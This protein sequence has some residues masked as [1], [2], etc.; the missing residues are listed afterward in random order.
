MPTSEQARF[1]PTMTFQWRSN[2]TIPEKAITYSTFCT[3]LLW[4]I[5]SVC[6]QLR[7]SKL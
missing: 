4:R 6:L 7:R 2:Q 3:K 5:P 1:W